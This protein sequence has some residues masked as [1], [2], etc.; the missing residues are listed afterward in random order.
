[1]AT[2]QDRKSDAWPALPGDRATAPTP[3]EDSSD[4]TWQEFLRL[5][6]AAA[7]VSSDSHERGTAGATKSNPRPSNATNDEPVTLQAAMEL[8][9][10]A[11]RACPKPARWRELYALLPLR[12]GAAA[13]LPTRERDWERTTAMTKRLVLRDHIEWAAATGTLQAVYRFLSGLPESDWDHFH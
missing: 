9:R 13:P 10:R 2:G 4:A 5:Q 3:I 6:T 11:N 12:D 8:I 7:P 1:M